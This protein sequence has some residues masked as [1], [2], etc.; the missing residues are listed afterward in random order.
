MLFAKINSQKGKEKWETAQVL[1]DSGASATIISKEFVKKLQIKKKTATSWGTAAGTFNTTGKV[2]LEIQFL[3]L[4]LSTAV[5][6]MESHV[7]KGQLASYN[8]ILGR[9]DLTE[10]GIDIKFSTQSIEWPHMNVTIP[11]K[12]REV[13]LYM[14]FLCG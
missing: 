2:N 10:L 14:H 4:S 6:H 1:I 11:M 12:P 3:E 7:H 13:T 9:N 5:V 8:M